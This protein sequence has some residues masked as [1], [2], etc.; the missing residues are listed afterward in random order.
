MRHVVLASLAVFS[1]VF[2]A[3]GLTAADAMLRTPWGSPDLQGV[4]D[5]H[6]ITPL[7]RGKEYEGRE[8][9]TDEEIAKLE[10]QATLENTDE[11]RQDDKNRDVSTAYN[12]FWWDRATRTTSKRTSLIIDPADGRIPAL[13]AEA[14]ERA[15]LEPTRAVASLGSGGRGA[16][17]PEDRSLW[18]RCITQGSTRLSA[19]AYNAN[20]QIFQTRDHVVILH[21]QIHEARIIPIG[22]KPHVPSNMRLWLGDS[23][24]R[25]DGDTLVVETTNFSDK[26]VFNG[27]T[28]GLRMVERFT[29]VDANTLGYDVTFSD[30]KTWTRPWT[31][32]MRLPKTQGEMYEYACHE[33]NV[34]LRGI[35]AGARQEEKEA[36]AARTTGSRQ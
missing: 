23:R 18:E 33:G 9:F 13:T 20:F 19:R 1:I 6:S 31:V 10:K 25:W 11:A 21:E 22:S 26:T 14:Q 15:K 17:D 34:G 36:A 16:N 27:S 3:V 12:D 4:W 30:P 24:G 5:R 29:R 8:F 32:Q 7:E 28:S 2:G 35:L